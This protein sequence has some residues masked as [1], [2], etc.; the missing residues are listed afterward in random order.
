[1]RVSRMDCLSNHAM[2]CHATYFTKITSHHTKTQRNATQRTLD[3]A[4]AAAAN[5]QQRRRRLPRR[6]PARGQGGGPGAGLLLLLL[7]PLP[8]E[9]ALLLALQERGAAKEIRDGGAAGPRG[10]RGGG[11]AEPP[12]AAAAPRRRPE[13]PPQQVAR[14][15]RGAAA[16][17]AAAAAAAGVEE[18]G[19]RVVLVLV[20]IAAAAAAAAPEPPPQPQAEAARLV[21]VGRGREEPLLLARPAAPTA[22][23]GRCLPVG[24]RTCMACRHGLSEF[25]WAGGSGHSR[26]VK[27]AIVSLVCRVVCTSCQPPPDAAINDHWIRFS[28]P[29]GWLAG[30]DACQS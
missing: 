11:G 21:L 20:L 22:V 27:S 16:R 24:V 5:H 17:V 1:M 12:A 19:G 23:H 28:A 25:V 14:A 29:W 2:P 7:A 4:P 10:P 26:Q 15:R 18:G 9:D 30:R 6:R 3:P 13:R 8:L